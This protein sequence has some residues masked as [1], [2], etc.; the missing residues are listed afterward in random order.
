[1]RQNWKYS[2]GQILISS[3][4]IPTTTNEV[5]ENATQL[6]SRKTSNTL[7]TV[8]TEA[9]RGATGREAPTKH[10]L[11]PALLEKSSEFTKEALATGRAPPWLRATEEATTAPAAGL[12]R[13]QEV[14]V[15][16]ASNR[17]APME[18]YARGCWSS[19]LEI[20]NHLHTKSL[21]PHRL[22]A[23]A[24]VADCGLRMASPGAC[25]S[26]CVYEDTPPRSASNRRNSFILQISY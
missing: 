13:A 18:F 19:K 14:A 9:R 20:L 22:R 17:T 23:V 12:A 10:A 4:D 11:R 5:K 1:M 6:L 24:R 25:S 16:I 7:Q 21:L 3:V 15:A 2:A 26:Q 8:R